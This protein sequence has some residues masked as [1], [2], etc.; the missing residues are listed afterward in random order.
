[1][2]LI[3]ASTIL[4]ILIYAATVILYLTVRKRLERRNGA[5]DL[6]PFELPVAIVAL[7]WLLLA[8]IVLVTPAAALVPL[9]IVIGLLLVGGLYF[10]GMLMFDRKS[11]WI[12]QSD[13]PIIVVRK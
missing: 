2:Q 13:I 5:F 3:T 10:V 1:L 6:G 8:L 4:P 9:L 7:L 11:L 12:E